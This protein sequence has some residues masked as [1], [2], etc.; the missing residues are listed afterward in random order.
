[1]NHA[2]NIT[3]SWKCKSKP[4]NY[5]DDFLKLILLLFVWPSSFAGS[6]HFASQQEESVLLFRGGTGGFG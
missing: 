6:R 2:L 1:M 4:Q 5:T 3:L